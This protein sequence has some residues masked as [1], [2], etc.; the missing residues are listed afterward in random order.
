MLHIDL[1]MEVEEE[2]ADP[3]ERG[4][5]SGIDQVHQENAQNCFDA[6]DDVPVALEDEDRR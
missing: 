1:N 4:L 5:D 3:E 6:D 2:N